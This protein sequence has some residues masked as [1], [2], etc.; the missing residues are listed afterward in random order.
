MISATRWPS[1]RPS[2]NAAIGNMVA[3]AAQRRMLWMFGPEG[4]EGYD[5]LKAEPPR[6][7]SKDSSRAA[8]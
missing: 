3:G 6:E 2:P 1:A 8:I 4:V 5:R 7:I